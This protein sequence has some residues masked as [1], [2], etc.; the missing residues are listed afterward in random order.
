MSI[1]LLCHAHKSGIS[2]RDVKKCQFFLMCDATKLS[3]DKSIKQ[4]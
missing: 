4:I 2:V 3:V 1:Q